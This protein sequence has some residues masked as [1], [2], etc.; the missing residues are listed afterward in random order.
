[1]KKYSEGKITVIDDLKK[2][3]EIQKFINDSLRT[4][5]EERTILYGEILE[6]RSNDEVLQIGKTLVLTRL[7]LMED[8]AVFSHFSLKIR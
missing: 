7:S 1:M 3:L 4:S 5:S 2:G 8:Y 6:E